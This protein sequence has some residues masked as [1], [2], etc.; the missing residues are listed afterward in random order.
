MID[1]QAVYNALFKLKSSGVNV[2]EQIKLMIDNPGVPRGIIEFLRD[3]SPQFQFYRYIQ[4][5]QKALAE[6]LLDYKELSDNDKLIVCSS[7]ITR[8]LIA[9]KYKELDE[10][11]LDDLN[12]SE[13]SD[14]LNFA[15]SANNY[16]KVNEVLKKHSESLRL[17][18][19]NTK[20]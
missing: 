15:L 17:F 7:F 14:A 8:A 1:R 9:V 19:K 5:R 13:V 11:L 6:N 20:V 10:S 16:S 2:D 3:N 4:K 18:Y 12:V